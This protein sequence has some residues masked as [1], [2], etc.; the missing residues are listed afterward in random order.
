MS[1]LFWPG[2]ERAGTNMTEGSFLA[3][4]VR[5]GSRLEPAPALVPVRGTSRTTTD[6]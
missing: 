5:V 6:G 1:D 2:D 3:A 4:M